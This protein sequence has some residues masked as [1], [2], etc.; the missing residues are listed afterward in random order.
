M[1]GALSGRPDHPFPAHRMLRAPGSA[2]AQRLHLAVQCRAANTKVTG[3]R[4]HISM[5]QGKG[6][7]DDIFLCLAK[8]DPFLHRQRTQKIGMGADH[9]IGPA[10]QHAGTMSG[11]GH[12]A[13]AVNGDQ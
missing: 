9:V 2:Q 12:F 13:I 3:R 4:R 6:G 8:T 10:C 7:A 5:R 11:T 1:R